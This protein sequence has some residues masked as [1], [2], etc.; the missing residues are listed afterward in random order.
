M[1]NLS[2]AMSMQIACPSSSIARTMS[3]SKL[4]LENLAQRQSLKGARVL[5]RADLNVPLKKNVT[6]AII[7]DDTRIRAVL[8]TLKLLQKSGART[9][10]CSHLG[11]PDGE[12][13]DELRLTPVAT[14][15]G[16]LLGSPIINLDD[17]VGPQV[18]VDIEALK[19][20]EIVLLENVR[21]YKQETK[22]DPEFAKQLA[23][24]ADIYV[25]DA[26]GTAHR[27]HA[28][29]E[30]VTNYIKTN[31]AGFLIEKE[32]KY[33]SGAVDAPLRPL[34]AIIGGAKVSTKIPVL[35]S[36]LQK[37]DKIMIGGG[38]IFTFYKAQGLDVGKSIIEEDKVEL[39]K[40][41]LDEA[42]KRGVHIVLP[43]D[44]VIADKFDADAQWKVVPA[45][46][47]PDDWLGLDIGPDSQTMFAEE[48]KECKTVVWNGP[49]GVFEFPNF[50]KGT[51]SVAEAL[52]ASTDNGVTTIVGGGDSVAAVEQAGLGSRM[53][54]IS[55][56]GG[57]SLELLEG[58]VLPGV[59]ALNNV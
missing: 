55:T 16:E 9:V 44:V 8:P 1:L 40:E 39:A 57:A 36:L 58:K 25:N 5:V 4:S 7:T 45:N 46:A 41:I 42:K 24:G 35:K 2:R 34:G 3:V 27:A 32:L 26:F 11:R 50:A 31:V 49:M 28:S 33:L 20:G 54:H 47:I 56:G 29:T 43:T 37:C 30:G 6:P 17:C 22:N 14:R 23:H 53:S 10:L 52:A 21:F 38:M 18:D 13:K 19:D 48:L 12:T 59:A 15:L 51:I